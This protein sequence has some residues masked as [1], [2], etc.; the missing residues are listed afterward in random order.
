MRAVA[1]EPQEKARQLQKELEDHEDEMTRMR[2]V[3]QDDVP[4]LMNI[5]TPTMQEYSIL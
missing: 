3:G 2:E 4:Y 5:F 1:P